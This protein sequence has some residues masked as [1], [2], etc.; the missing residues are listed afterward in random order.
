VPPE[1]S[2]CKLVS[3]W[4]FAAGDGSSLSSTFAGSRSGAGPVEGR[5]VVVLPDCRTRRMRV[6]NAVMVRRTKCRWRCGAVHRKCR[7][8]PMK[9]KFCDWISKTKEAAACGCFDI[10]GLALGYFSPLVGLINS[11]FFSISRRTTCTFVA[12]SD[13]PE[14][15]YARAPSVASPCACY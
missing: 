6:L 11:I 9:A 15:I 4:A 8:R 2:S 7:P 1:C 13:W 3:G 12:P 10:L 5:P 14:F